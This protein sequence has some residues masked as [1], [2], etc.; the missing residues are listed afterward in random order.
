MTTICCD[1][2]RVMST[3]L[4]LE[5]FLNFRYVSRDTFSIVDGVFENFRYVKVFNHY[6]KYLPLLEVNNSNCRDKNSLK[7]LRAS[8]SV[9]RFFAKNVMLLL[10]KKDCYNKKTKTFVRESEIFELFTRAEKYRWP[11]T[12]SVSCAEIMYIIV[13]KLC[14]SRKHEVLRRFTECEFDVKSET[15]VCDIYK[16]ACNA[17]DSDNE[18]EFEELCALLFKNISLLHVTNKLVKK[19][20]NDSL[21][22][23]AKY[24]NKML[25]V[26]LNSKLYLG[27]SQS[28]Y[29]GNIVFEV[30]HK[31]LASI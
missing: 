27:V 18:N 16:N 28:E 5:D 25:N 9:I 30:L 14:K 13:S 2:L 1:I 3:Y 29:F 17:I 10:P 22:E 4:K 26:L 24:L 15:D 19:V 8:Y 7:I 31:K 20:N 21:N 11:L 6:V 23:D 12:E